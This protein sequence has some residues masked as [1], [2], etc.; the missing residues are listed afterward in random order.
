MTGKKGQTVRNSNA[1]KG[2]KGELHVTNYND[3]KP[4][5]ARESYDVHENGA[6]SGHHVTVNK[7]DGTDVKVNLQ[8]NDYNLGDLY[9][10]FDED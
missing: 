6:R 5:A 10:N 4:T 1:G 8:T 2:E 9:G 7:S 3:G